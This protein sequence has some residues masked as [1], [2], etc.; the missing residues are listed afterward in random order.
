MNR[1]T[2]LARAF[3]RRDIANFIGVREA[4]EK[5]DHVIAE[6]LVYTFLETYR[7]KLPHVVTTTSREN[8]LRDVGRRRAGGRVLV[9]DL[10]EK[11]IGT[12]ALL[13]P[14]T[15]VYDGWLP[16]HGNL[17]CVAVAP[18]FQGLRFSQV[19]LDEAEI[20]AREWGLRGLCLHV[21]KGAEGVARLYQE[22]GFERDTRGDMFAHQNHYEGYSMRWGSRPELKVP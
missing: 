5:D 13:L 14:G 20:L 17:R 18:A 3:D 16:D 2:G 4:R 6:L 22:R 9:L 10:G 7:Q 15:Q 19:L 8:D 12:C 21:Q 11:V 1:R